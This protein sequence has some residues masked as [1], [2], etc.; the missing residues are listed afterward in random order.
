M[1]RLHH[2]GV[3]TCCTDSM[4][5]LKLGPV[6]WS[7]FCSSTVCG[8]LTGLH[9]LTYRTHESA[10]TVSRAKGLIN[11][12]EEQTNNSMLCSSLHWLNRS[13]YT[14]CRASSLR[15]RSMV[16]FQILTRSGQGT[17]G[18]SRTDAG[19]IDIRQWH[20]WKVPVATTA[21]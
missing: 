2:S 6:P 16:N 7:T 11:G 14:P 5:A 18:P 12:L 1:P 20:C 19:A 9:D 3:R 10:L 21:A 4:R 13:V 8:S 17:A 15:A